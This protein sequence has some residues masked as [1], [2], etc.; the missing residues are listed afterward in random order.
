VADVIQEIQRL[1]GKEHIAPHV[2]PA[3]HG[4]ILQQHMAIDKARQMLH[5]RPRYDL[6]TGLA[7]TVEWYVKFLDGLML[8]FG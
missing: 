7:E 2:V 1:L 3:T 8:S 6:T 5:W 4:E